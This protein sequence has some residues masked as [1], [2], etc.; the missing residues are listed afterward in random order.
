VERYVLPSR[1]LMSVLQLFRVAQEV[2]FRFEVSEG[3]KIGESEVT[4]PDGSSRTLEVFDDT[5]VGFGP[6]G[7]EV[8][9]V[10]VQEQFFERS[11]EHVNSL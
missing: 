3:R 8:A 9:R 1:R 5:V 6:S 4:M 2:L 10:S 7:N 11:D